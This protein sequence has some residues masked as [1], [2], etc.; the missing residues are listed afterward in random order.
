VIEITI[1]N[2]VPSSDWQRLSYKYAKE[3]AEALGRDYR[4][5]EMLIKLPEGRCFFKYA[6][7]ESFGG[8]R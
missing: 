2:S 8:Y 3:Y 6:G 4:D 1:D 7:E 5:L